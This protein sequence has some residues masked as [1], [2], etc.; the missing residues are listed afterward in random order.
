M[1]THSMNGSQ[2][3]CWMKEVRTKKG[4][5]S[6]IPFMQNSRKCTLPYTDSK[7]TSSCPK[8]T[9]R[10]KREG[11]TVV[12]ISLSGLCDAVHMCQNWWHMCSL[13]HVSYTQQHNEAVIGGS[14]ASFMCHPWAL[15]YESM[16]DFWHFI[17]CI[18]NTF[19]LFWCLCFLSSLDDSLQYIF[20]WIFWRVPGEPS[21]GRSCQWR[22]PLFKLIVICGDPLA[23]MEWVQWALPPYTWVS[24]FPTT[25]CCWSTRKPDRAGSVPPHSGLWW[26]SYLALYSIWTNGSSACR[27]TK[28]GGRA[29]DSVTDLLTF[30]NWT[31]KSG[32]RPAV[33]LSI[34]VKITQH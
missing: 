31:I 33:T 30:R 11:P 24:P 13:L 4:P 8:M 29:T 22:K 7:Q 17:W 32:V 1:D 3:L 25:G 10:V 15:E 12:G 34:E 2:S 20:T 18:K 27:S 16:G 19:S 28:H 26:F 6:V 21:L 14:V 5:Y 9:K 23:A